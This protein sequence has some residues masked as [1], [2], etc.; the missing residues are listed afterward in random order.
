MR[1]IHYRVNY[2]AKVIK[3]CVSFI[4]VEEEHVPGL[5]VSG[6]DLERPVCVRES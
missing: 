4:T 6:D 1:I 3:I 5:A 2:I